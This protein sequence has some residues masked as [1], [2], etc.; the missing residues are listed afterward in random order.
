[1]KQNTSW[2]AISLSTFKLAKSW[3]EK[4]PSPSHQYRSLRQ[5]I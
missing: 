5:E 4:Q 1:M 2:R 3:S